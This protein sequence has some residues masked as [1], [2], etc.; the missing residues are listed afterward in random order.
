MTLTD[1]SKISANKLLHTVYRIKNTKPEITDK[2]YAMGKAIDH[3]LGAG[4]KQRSGSRR[5]KAGGGN[6]RERKLDREMKELR[7]GIARISNELHRRKSRGKASRKEKAI[8]QNLKP[9]L[10][11]NNLGSKKLRIV[12][13]EWIDRLRYKKIKMKKYIE[14]KARIQDNIIYQRDQKSFFKKVEETEVREVPEMEKF[15]EY[16]GGIWERKERTPN[17]PWMEEMKRQLSEKVKIVQEFDI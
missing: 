6:R 1:Q 8:I 15:V 11:I 10:N 5:Q 4:Q 12:K 2:V 16:W 9:K 14:L 17:M 3:K 7:Q 13:E